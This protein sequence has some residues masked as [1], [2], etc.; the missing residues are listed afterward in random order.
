MS[1]S[2]EPE[3]IHLAIADDGIGFK[4]EQSD[5]SHLLAEKHFGLAGMDERAGLIGADLK[6]VSAP[7]EGT[8]V[9]II[10]QPKSSFSPQN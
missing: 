4:L 3:K 8:R 9:T 10:W 5:F 7:G 2:L 6:I 1:G